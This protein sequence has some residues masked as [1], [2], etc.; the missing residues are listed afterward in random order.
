MGCRPPRIPIDPTAGGS[1]PHPPPPFLPA[2]LLGLGCCGGKVPPQPRR[3]GWGVRASP[4]RRGQRGCG[5]AVRFG[6][7]GTVR[8][9]DGT[10]TVAGPGPGP[11]RGRLCSVPSRTAERWQQS[12][13]A[14]A[15]QGRA[16]CTSPLWL[17]QKG[18]REPLVLHGATASSCTSLPLAVVEQYSWRGAGGVGWFGGWVGGWGAVLDGGAGSRAVG[19]PRPPAALGRSHA[20]YSPR[21][22]S[23]GSEES[24]SSALKVPKRAFPYLMAGR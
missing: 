20:A 21:P 8:K 22:V 1:Q 23:H 6:G 9:G 4:G 10:V 17:A 24:G 12:G 13:A 5:Q 3:G 14:H 16:R 7:A 19:W 18:C 11:G 2:R 15:V